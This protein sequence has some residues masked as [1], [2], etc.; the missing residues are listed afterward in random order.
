[1]KDIVADS[2]IR[3]VSTV[4]PP[5]PGTSK[6]S[7]Y[8]LYAAR[9]PRPRYP[10]KGKQ[11]VGID[12]VSES[13]RSV[14]PAKRPA[15]TLPFAPRSNPSLDFSAAGTLATMQS[16]TSRER[17][18]TAATSLEVED[19]GN[20]PTDEGEEEQ[21]RHKEDGEEEEEGPFYDKENILAWL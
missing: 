11:A 6:T 5:S 18:S 10:G 9:R 16:A 13:S 8:D 1:M 20:A 12:P 14:S 15:P 17:K 21:E 3:P 7:R 4:D 2:S 19:Y